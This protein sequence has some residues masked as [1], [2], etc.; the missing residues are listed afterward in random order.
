MIKKLK[1]FS[2]YPLQHERSAEGGAL[3]SA[4]WPICGVTYDL[5]PQEKGSEGILVSSATLSIIVLTAKWSSSKIQPSS[6]CER[7]E[8]TAAKLYAL[9]RTSL[10]A[11]TLVSIRQS[12]KGWRRVPI[13][14]ERSRSPRFTPR[15]FPARGA[16]SLGVRI[17]S[18][19]P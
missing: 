16:N 1:P 2:F 4:T 11:R 17:I 9:Q 13:S 5:H 10:H 7:T 8:A 15:G 12:R 6:T 19:M 18:I 14:A 3:R